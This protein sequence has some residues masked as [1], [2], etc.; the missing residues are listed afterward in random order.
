MATI[1][2]KL[3]SAK[4]R[5]V[6]RFSLRSLLI[7]VTLLSVW[8]AWRVDRAHRQ[9]DA[10]RAIRDYGGIVSYDYQIA[11]KSV[12]ARPSEPAW[13]IELVGVDFF[14]RVDA[15]SFAGDPYDPRGKFDAGVFARL[16][17]LPY[18]THVALR[19]NQACDETFA[20]LANHLPKLESIDVEPF[21]ADLIERTYPP[22]TD[23]G[24]EKLTRLSSLQYLWFG[25]VALSDRSLAALGRMPNLKTAYVYGDAC[26][27]TD[28]GLEELGGLKQ[29]TQLSI[30][31]TSEGCEVTDRG[32]AS[33]CDLKTLE[34]LGV[35]G[36]AISDDAFLLLA[37]S[38]PKLTDL[39]VASERLTEQGIAEFARRS[40]AQ[41]Y[42]TRYRSVAQSI[43][44]EIM[45]AHTIDD[46]RLPVELSIANLNADRR[47]F[48]VLKFGRR[49]FQ[50]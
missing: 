43:R 9:R 14:H 12:D 32:L 47:E 33:L 18:V 5:R 36:R 24:V 10:V 35:R 38:L 41:L 19:G 26:K 8:L 21:A 34:F 2:E 48:V 49:L 3:R 30:G 27:F 4:P 23:A 31:V 16:A 25:E 40:K 29:I 42:L 15:V 11:A 13:L 37:D 28:A 22:L 7:V 44:R 50:A 20:I 45:A 17:D 1:I 39:E 6:F 46:D